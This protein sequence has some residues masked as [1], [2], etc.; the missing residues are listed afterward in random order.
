MLID[1][2]GKH[3]EREPSKRVLFLN[4]SAV[5]PILTE[6]DKNGDSLQRYSSGSAGPAAADRL[7]NRD[8]R[9]W[10]PIT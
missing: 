7:L 9:S 10:L 4:Y 3:N 6:W 8:G 2:I 1:A 5:D